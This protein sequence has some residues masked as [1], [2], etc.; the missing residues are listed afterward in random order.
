MNVKSRT[1][2]LLNYLIASLKDKMYDSSIYT[3]IGEYRWD[4]LLWK[5][6]SDS[7]NNLIEKDIVSCH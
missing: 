7:L 3:Y 5:L 2:I 4:K 6:I 1:S